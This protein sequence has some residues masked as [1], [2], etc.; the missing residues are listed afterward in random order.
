ML[1][2]ILVFNSYSSLAVKN[3]KWAVKQVC[4]LKLSLICCKKNGKVYSKQS[5]TIKLNSS[6]SSVET[7]HPSFYPLTSGH[8][9][10]DPSQIPFFRA[11][12]VYTW[13]VLQFKSQEQP[14]CSKHTYTR[15]LFR[16]LPSLSMSSAHRS[17]KIS[18][19]LRRRPRQICR[20]IREGIQLWKE[21]LPCSLDP[22]P[23]GKGP[24]PR[25]GLSSY[26]QTPTIIELK[27]S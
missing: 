14:I 25:K 24:H 12:Q 18:L 21:L 5:Y 7:G 16:L 26:F 1:N 23:T 10:T 4:H 3:L 19:Q 20:M 13:A 15:Q 8:K 27:V 22:D 11:M 2:V 17:S 6:P 9:T